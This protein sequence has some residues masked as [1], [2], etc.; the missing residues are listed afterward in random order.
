MSSKHRDMQ[1]EF[2]RALAREA[3][4]L[5]AMRE[6]LEAQARHTQAMFELASDEI[7]RTK[8]NLD[9]ARADAAN[10]RRMLLQSSWQ[11]V[12]SLKQCILEI[13]RS[14]MIDLRSYVDLKKTHTA[15][16]RSKLA[17]L[18]LP[19]SRPSSPLPYVRYVSP[20]QGS[21]SSTSPPHA[22]CIRAAAVDDASFDAGSS[23][24]CDEPSPF[25]APSPRARSS[26]NSSM[27]HWS[28]KKPFGPSGKTISP[29]PREPPAQPPWFPDS[30][31]PRRE[32]QREYTSSRIT[33]A[34]S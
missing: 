27:P 3:S 17:P 1:E 28:P 19:T 22:Q 20:G 32:P 34:V 9:D 5:D 24:D 25:E 15:Q 23:H 8:Q 33:N 6:T 11:Q 16:M 26:L 2:E 7:V 4:K 21:E 14:Q 12:E 18:L 30:L 31:A 29:R 10:E 13:N